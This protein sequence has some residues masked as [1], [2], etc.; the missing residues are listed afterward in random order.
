MILTPGGTSLV[1][2]KRVHNNNTGGCFGVQDSILVNLRLEVSVTQV[3]NTPVK[4][5]KSTYHFNVWKLLNDRA[6]RKSQKGE[7]KIHKVFAN[8]SKQDPLLLRSIRSFNEKLILDLEVAMHFYFSCDYDSLY[9]LRI[10]TCMRESFYGDICNWREIRSFI[11]D[12]HF[13][14]VNPKKKRKKFWDDGLFERS[15]ALTLQC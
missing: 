8:F 7:E 9:E 10:C 13:H 4:L 1:N 3:L 14:M 15:S 5:A 6:N 11:V 2:K 12:E